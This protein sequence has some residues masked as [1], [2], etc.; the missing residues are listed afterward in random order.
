MIDSVVGCSTEWRG[1]VSPQYVACLG[2]ATCFFFGCD[3][4]VY[5]NV[6]CIGGKR[7]CMVSKEEKEEKEK[8]LSQFTS[9]KLWEMFE[10]TGI[11][12]DGAIFDE[13]EV[14]AYGVID[15]YSRF[16]KGVRLMDALSSSESVSKE[17]IESWS[18][19]IAWRYVKYV[20]EE[21]YR[22]PMRYEN[23]SEWERDFVNWCRGQFGDWIVRSQYSVG[24]IRVDVVIGGVGIELKIPKD[25]RA[26]MML[27]G[28]VDAYRKHFGRRFM[29]LLITSFL[30]YPD[31][32]EFR[33]DME[34]KGVVVIEKR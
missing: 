4:R 33:D 23:E 28:Q 14:R 26:L 15:S 7:D 9:A 22:L 27:R 34:K 25:N 20:I 8:L 10:E 17:Y 31:V 16:E 11:E 19:R 1:G 6:W 2:G 24:G 13:E 30:D 21:S 32:V 12:V 29:V 5:E 3:G 18:G